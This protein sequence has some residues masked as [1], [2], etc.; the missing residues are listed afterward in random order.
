MHAT[1]FLFP[2]LRQCSLLQYT[3]CELDISFNLFYNQGMEPEQPPCH[4]QVT[5]IILRAQFQGFILSNLSTYF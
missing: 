4:G 1:C 2:N 3:V 5:L